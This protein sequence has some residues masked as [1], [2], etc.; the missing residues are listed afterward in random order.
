MTDASQATIDEI[1]KAI[2]QA[3]RLK[4]EPEA[5]GLDDKL[6]GPESLGL[7][8]ID[9]FDLVTDV[10]TKFG[11]TVPDDEIPKLNSVSAILAFVQ[12]HRNG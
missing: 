7:H 9:T 11:V 2:V 12:N 3:G 10:E 5:I 6:Y 1:R 8:S 4:I